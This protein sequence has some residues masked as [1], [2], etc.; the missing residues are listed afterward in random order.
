MS[1]VQREVSMELCQRTGKRIIS[2][3]SN[4]MNEFDGS[5]RHHILSGNTTATDETPIW[6]KM[7]SFRM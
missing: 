6:M 1:V 5:Q 7:T 4:T 3:E 2:N